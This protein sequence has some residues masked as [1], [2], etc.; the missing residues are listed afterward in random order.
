MLRLGVAV[1]V[2]TLSSA[3]LAVTLSSHAVAGDPLATTSSDVGCVDVPPVRVTRYADGGS[4]YEFTTPDGEDLHMP[5]PPRGFKPLDATSAQRHRYGFP[6]PPSD[7]AKRAE[8]VTAMQAYVATDDPELCWNSAVPQP[9]L[10][11][12]G[13]DAS[14]GAATSGNWGGY[15]T[16]AASGN[17][18]DEVSGQ[19][20][21]PSRGTSCPSSYESAWVG[22][23]GYQTRSDGKSFGLIQD[24]T[25]YDP[26]GS[27]YAWWEY[28]GKNATGAGIGVAEQRFP[29]TVS[30]GDVIY[31]DTTWTNGFAQFEMEN[32]T[33]GKAVGIGLSLSSA[34]YDGRNAEWIIERPTIANSLP[35]LQNFGSIR[36]AQ[37]KVRNSLGNWRYISQTSEQ[38]NVTMVNGAN[39]LA[40]SSALSGENGGVFT[41]TYVHCK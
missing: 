19:W 3:V 14:A 1:S 8:W 31:A 37:A 5:Q 26:S 6:D 30:P 35:S 40:T 34:Y 12:L 9:R 29:L 22:I 7:D 38:Y 23:G 13:G 32:V 39:D 27:P 4:D 15:V 18:Y 25:A 2:L 33:T 16:K 17:A 10:G 28:I 21:Q 36:F 24:G 41:S 11:S 20:R